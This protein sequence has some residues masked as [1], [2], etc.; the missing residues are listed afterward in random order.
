MTT[1]R[2]LHART[3]VQT[4]MQI[5]VV[6]ELT[7]QRKHTKEYHRDKMACQCSPSPVVAWVQFVPTCYSS[8]CQF[9]SGQD[10]MEG[11]HEQTVFPV[12]C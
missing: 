4:H 5:L 9:L 11:L 8:D 7:F 3:V 12:A 6:D 10:G 2:Q 1:I